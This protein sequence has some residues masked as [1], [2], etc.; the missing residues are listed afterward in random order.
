MPP[1]DRFDGI[2]NRNFRRTRDTSTE[3]EGEPAEKVR[4]EIVS[5]EQPSA[6]YGDIRPSPAT[7]KRPFDDVR[8]ITFRPQP[9]TD[10]RN[11]RSEVPNSHTLDQS[12]PFTMSNEREKSKQPSYRVRNE[13]FKDGL[14]E[15]VA[16]KVLEGTVQ[17]SIEEMLGISS[18][19]KKILERKLKNRRVEPKRGKSAYVAVLTDNGETQI[20]EMPTGVLM[21]GNYIDI[22]DLALAPEIMFEYLSEERDGMPAG[23]WVQKDV[24]EC[25]HNDLPIDDERRDMIVVAGNSKGLRSIAARINHRNEIVEGILDSGSQIVSIDRLVATQ[26]GLTWDP[27]VTLQMQDSHGGLGRTEGL[28]RNVPFTFGDLT[29]YLQL[30]VQNRAPYMLLMGRPFDA[31]TESNVKTFANGDTELTITCPNS[32]RQCVVPTFA[33]GKLANVMKV[34]TSR[35][36]VPNYK[37]L[38][39]PEEP[40]KAEPDG[41]F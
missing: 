20:P 13:L 37:K 31:L 3:I 12:H 41:N 39:T 1:R 27:N 17:L 14:A 11:R 2:P 5:K 29:I 24:V 32:K 9:E 30:H 15:E 7:A 4:T 35:Y 22:D 10:V 26:L 23:S 34:D 21:R 28:A 25:F 40:S 19:V 8:P 16:T 33:R 38:P 6:G 18:L 36:E